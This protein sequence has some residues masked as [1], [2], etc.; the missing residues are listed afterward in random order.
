MC[1]HLVFARPPSR[2]DKSSCWKGTSFLCSTDILVHQIPCISSNFSKVPCTTYTGSITFA[3]TTWVTLMP[4]AM[5]TGVAVRYF[6]AT[7]T[8]LLLV[9]NSVWIFH[10]VQPWGK[11]GPSPPFRVCVITCMLVPKNMVFILAGMILDEKVS[12]SSFFITLT[13]LFQSVR[14]MVWFAAISLPMTSSAW[15]H[16]SKQDI[17]DPCKEANNSSISLSLITFMI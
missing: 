1:G 14:T 6:T 8:C 12:T 9:V 15:W 13:A 2:P 16:A 3:A 4:L 11:Q 10:D 7:A 5:V 17:L